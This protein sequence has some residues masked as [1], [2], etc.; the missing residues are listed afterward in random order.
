MVT[1]SF[2]AARPRRSSTTQ[3]THPDSGYWALDLQSVALR[4]ASDQLLPYLASL[5]QATGLS[6]SLAV[7]DDVEV[8]YLQWRA[9]SVEA[10]RWLPCVAGSCAPWYCTASAK[11]LLAGLPEDERRERVQRIAFA[12][13]E[14]PI[15]WAA[16]S[17]WCDLAETV[18]DEVG[19][20][21]EDSAVGVQAIA[22][23]VTGEAGRVVGALELVG[24]KPRA[25]IDRMQVDHLEALREAA[26][27]ISR[28]GRWV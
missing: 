15:G 7:L 26:E 4:T 19:V 5:A 17:L 18:W 9:A 11:V 27:E 23:G 28:V 16:S 6:V 10:E 1:P 24:F 13:G 8:V 14:V 3:L 25:C 2:E 21:D 20:D 22:V 12:E